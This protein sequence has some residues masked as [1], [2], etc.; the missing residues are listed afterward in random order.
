MV[1]CL[2]NYVVLMMKFMTSVVCVGLFMFLFVTPAFATSGRTNSQGCHNSKKA[3][4][5]CHG[6]PGPKKVSKPAYQKPA[7]TQPAPT[8]K[9]VKPVG[10]STTSS[11][12]VGVEPD[13]DTID[14]GAA[15]VQAD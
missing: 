7:P 10:G 11:A 14:S 2:T 1:Q 4:Y 15:T 9:P 12:D 5:H 13:A 8:S 3:G 6:T